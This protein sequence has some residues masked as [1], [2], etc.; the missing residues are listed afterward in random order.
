MEL[1]QLRYLIGVCEAGGV[2]AASK[3]LHVA[4][5]AL[6]HSIAALESELGVK[7]FVRTNRGMT[8]TNAGGTMLEHARVVLADIER[9]RN[10]VQ[11]SVHDIQGKVVVGLP[12]TV[13][14]IAALPI[15]RAAKA[16]FPELRLKIIESHSGFLSEWLH[17]GRLDVSALFVSGIESTFNCRLLLEERLA[18]VTRPEDIPTTREVSIQSL[19]E[20]PLVLPAQEHGLRRIIDRVCDEHGVTLEVIAEID[21]LP[22]IKKAVQE[23]IASTILSPGAV[24]DEVQAGR[25]AFTTIA[26]P[27]IVR[28]VACATS[29]TRP[30]TPAT[31]AMI[32]L[33]TEQ[34]RA[35]ADA[36]L[37]P[38]MWI[39][40]D[41]C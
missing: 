9:A 6:S 13:A 39:G 24:V 3:K 14:L 2:L 38:A 15:L 11:H 25:L 17:D 33:I 35:L 22:S 32:S 30:M 37:W 5:P 20:R 40:D 26:R 8:L 34:V 29:M 31:G 28:Q 4:Q 36:G 19:S 27:H 23:G 12:T 41:S 16:K 18:L 10:A 21:S 7:L 1:R